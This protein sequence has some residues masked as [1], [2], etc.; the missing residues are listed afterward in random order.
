MNQIE[1]IARTYTQAPWRKQLQLIVLF[2]LGV[3]SVA[4]VAGIYL[5]ISARSTAVGRDIQQMQA[6]I[7]NYNR[8]N[9]DLQ[10]HLARI[11]S[12]SQM[13]ARAHDLNFESVPPDQIVYLVVPGY[14]ERQPIVLAPSTERSVIRAVSMPP[15]YTESIFAW[16]VRNTRDW[17]L[18]VIEEKP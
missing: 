1:T 17:Y 8:E 18:T 15:E 12:S 3:V 9:E 13:E 7:A 11:L 5:N 2:S 16:L 4:I 10:S 14:S 6:E